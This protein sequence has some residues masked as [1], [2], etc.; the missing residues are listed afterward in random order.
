M[1]NAMAS[2]TSTT[3]ETRNSQNKV[4]KGQTLRLG[5]PLLFVYLLQL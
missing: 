3:E 1:E 4:M 2:M 5:M